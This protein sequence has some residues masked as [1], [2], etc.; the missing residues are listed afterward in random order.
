[1]SS[2]TR[3][4]LAAIIC[5]N[6][7]SCATSDGDVPGNAHNPGASQYVASSQLP[8][9]TIPPA[10]PYTLPPWGAKGSPAPPALCIPNTQGD[11]WSIGFAALKTRPDRD[12]LENDAAGVEVSL[13]NGACTALLTDTTVMFTTGFKKYENFKR[14]DL[15]EKAAVLIYLDIMPTYQTGC[16]GNL[17]CDQQASYWLGGPQNKTSCSL[18]V[19]AAVIHTALFGAGGNM[20]EQKT[21]LWVGTKITD[22]QACNCMEYLDNKKTGLTDHYVYGCA[23]PISI[24]M[25]KRLDG[26]SSEGCRQQWSTGHCVAD[27]NPMAFDPAAYLKPPKWNAETVITYSPPN[28]T[29]TKSIN[30]ATM[31]GQAVG[32]NAD[33]YGIISANSSDLKTITSISKLTSTSAIKS[34]TVSAIMSTKSSTIPASSVT[35][36]LPK[37]VSAGGGQRPGQPGT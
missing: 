11:H 8:V 20:R 3:L 15:S 28:S 18:R 36:P 14:W 31:V 34:T 5:F 9:P 4:C 27:P 24:D 12:W 32:W 22:G 7:F 35:A 6:S 10:S 25:T 23:C 21:N 30:P 33:H 26:E 37:P 1:M 29:T 13:W 2:I 17:G 16:P 19:G